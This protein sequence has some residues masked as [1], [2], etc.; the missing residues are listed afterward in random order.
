MSYQLRKGLMIIHKKVYKEIKDILTA[1]KR[2]DTLDENVVLECFWDHED[3]AKADEKHAIDVSRKQKLGFNIHSFDQRLNGIGTEL[4]ELS[5][6]HISLSIQFEYNG[7]NDNVAYE[8]YEGKELLWISLKTELK[9]I[10]VMKIT[11]ELK[12]GFECKIFE[13]VY[14]MYE[15]KKLEISDI[16]NVKK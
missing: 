6:N 11:K 12:D 10:P 7:N 15:L 1:Y 3:L 16:A 9:A 13:K 8:V 4:K 5:K 14:K 2:I